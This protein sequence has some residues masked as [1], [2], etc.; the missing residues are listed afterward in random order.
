M[1]APSFDLSRP[2]RRESDARSRYLAYRRT[3]NEL[4]SQVMKRALPRDGLIRAGKALGMVERT[5]FIF[6][7]EEDMAILS[8]FALHDVRTRGKTAIERYR[9]TAETIS[10]VEEKI[11]DAHAAAATSLFRVTA[12]NPAE[13]TLTLEDLLQPSRTVRLTDI[14]LSHSATP[15]MLIFTRCVT[16]EEITS[17][18]GVAFVFPDYRDKQL[19]ADYLRERRRVKAG[20]EGRQRFEH[21]Y[22]AHRLF[23]NPIRYQ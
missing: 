1:G 5:I 17:T 14:Q 15:N 13:D 11:L 19:V 20:Q 6:E 4:M 23:G 2:S 22:R 10:P 9:E 16:F 21:F 3:A 12:T 7:S 18:S 8:D